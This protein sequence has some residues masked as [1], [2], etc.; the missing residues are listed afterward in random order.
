[1]GKDRK[2]NVIRVEVQ[3]KVKI[4]CEMK[5]KRILYLIMSEGYIVICCI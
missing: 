3:E 5:F 2:S 1:M 4:F